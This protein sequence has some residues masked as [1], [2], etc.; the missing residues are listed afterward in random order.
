MTIKNEWVRY[1]DHSGYLAW[2]ESAKRPLPAVIVI[3]EV[4]GVDSHIQDVTR[5]FAGAGY[6]ALAPDLYAKAGVRPPSLSQE[7]I[8][9]TQTFIRHLPPGAWLDQKIRETELLKLPEPQ[10]SNNRETFD[11]LFAGM[12]TG[13]IRFDQ[14]I[15]PLKASVRYLRHECAVSSGQKVGCVG[16]CMGGGLSALL[17]CHDEDLSGAVMFYG[18]SP[19]ADLVSAIPCLVL[20]FYGS[21]DTRVNATL[22]GFIEAMKNAGRQFEHHLYEGAGHG[23]FNDSRLSYNADA[24]RGAF[25]RTLAFF[26]QTLVSG[27]HVQ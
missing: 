8:Q 27:P 21:L 25:V 7:R 14:Y 4:Y 15:A 23:F 11:T 19:P 24:A 20:G 22:P 2:P 10:Q 12:G 5:R 26:E 9:E 1:G 17:A 3:Q 16:F 13:G 6:A 18:T